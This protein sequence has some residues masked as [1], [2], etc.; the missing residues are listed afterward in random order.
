MSGESVTAAELAALELFAGLPE[1]ELHDLAAVASRRR[2]ADGEALVLQGE[3]WEAVYWLTAGRI[4]LRMEHEGR[5]V[6]VMTLAPGDLLGWTALR[7]EPLALV[8]ARAVGPAELVSLPFDP[9][10]D[11]L[12]GG[13]P[14]A[15]L[16]FRRLIGA[17]ARH[18]Q[19]TRVQLLR[20]GSEGVISAG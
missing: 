4:A 20:P 11:L 8:T 16:A 17:A 18:L 7:E 14:A 1:T 9:L 15:R 3:R 2:L 19:D 13:G 12:T 5:R 10:L 6:L